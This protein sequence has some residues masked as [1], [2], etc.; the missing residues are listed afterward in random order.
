MSRLIYRIVKQRKLNRVI[1]RLASNI[2][3]QIHYTST[4][5]HLNRNIYTLM[6]NVSIVS[7]Y[8]QEIIQKHIADHPTA[9]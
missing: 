3:A 7:E 4:L 6:Q 1:H 5:S 9:P 8:D 2:T